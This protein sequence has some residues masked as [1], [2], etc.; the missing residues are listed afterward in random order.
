VT[1][2]WLLDLQLHEIEAAQRSRIAREVGGFRGLINT[3]DAINEAVIMPVFDNG[4]NGITRLARRVGRL[5]MIRLAFEE[6][7]AA[8]PDAELH[9]NDFDL[10]ADYEHAIE[11][12]LGAGIRIDGIGLQTHMHQGYR[13]EDRALEAA[14]RFARF[15]IPLHFTE[16]TLLSGDLMPPEIVDLNDY[17]VDD[18]PSTPEGEERQAD[19]IER[20]YRSLVAHSAVHSITYWGLTDEGAWLGAPAGLVRKDATPKPAYDRLRSLIKGE[21]WLP[22]TVFRTDS[23]GRLTVTGMAGTYTVSH[24]GTHTEFAL[25]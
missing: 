9:I 21:W 12:A 23:A 1:A 10:S 19:D 18:W 17:Q 4:D 22:S 6:A 7:R 20:H 2:P 5:G 16:T 11:E 15:G 24:A 3:W 13:G 14:D 8:N 25:E